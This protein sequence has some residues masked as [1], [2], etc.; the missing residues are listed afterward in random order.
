MSERLGAQFVA[1]LGIVGLFSAPVIMLYVF[2]RLCLAPVIVFLEGL[3]PRQAIARSRQLLDELSLPARRLGRGDLVAVGLF[4]LTLVLQLI[5]WWSFLIP[6]DILQQ[7]LASAGVAENSI[8]W[9]AVYRSIATLAPFAAFVLLHPVLIAG[10]VL[11][12]YDRRIRV[13][14]LDIQLLAQNV[15]QRG[16]ADFEI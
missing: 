8:L 2:G 12:Y 15:W 14:G 5:F 7:Y 10:V 13:E 6:T 3:S 1:V 16:E 4:L 9:M 11:L